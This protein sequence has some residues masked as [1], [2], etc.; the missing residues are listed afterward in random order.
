MPKFIVTQ[1]DVK[2]PISRIST[3]RSEIEFSVHYP[4]DNPERSL[5]DVVQ[6]MAYVGL[7]DGISA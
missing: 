2:Q 5:P 1:S 3:G 7:F 4:E 6:V